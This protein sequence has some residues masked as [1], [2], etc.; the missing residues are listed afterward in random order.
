M[1]LSLPFVIGL[2]YIKIKL[3]VKLGG[4]KITLGMSDPNIKCILAIINIVSSSIEALEKR[5]FF[6]E[7]CGINR[8]KE[9]LAISDLTSNILKG[10]QNKYESMQHRIDCKVYDKCGSKF[11]IIE[12]TIISTVRAE[13][14]FISTKLPFKHPPEGHEVLKG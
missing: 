6:L 2:M 4:L 5:T 11:D 14:S 13:L 9:I 12:N 1:V 8:K 7:E 3:Q 10:I